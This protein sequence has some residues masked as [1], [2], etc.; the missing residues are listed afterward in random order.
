[1]GYGNV[2]PGCLNDNYTYC[3]ECEEY[4]PNGDMNY[5]ER[6]EKDVCDD[7]LEEY[8]TRCEKC[9]EWILNGDMYDEHTCN[10][11]H[12]AKEERK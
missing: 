10:D 3:D 6:Y 1:M 8:Y 5:L 12:T 7:C 11:C 2:C 9:G 4:H